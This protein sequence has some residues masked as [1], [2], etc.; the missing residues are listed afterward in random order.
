MNPTIF[1]R[2]LGRANSVYKWLKKS[3]IF[4]FIVETSLLFGAGALIDWLTSDEK[5]NPA[6]FK[7][8][9]PLLHAEVQDDKIGFFVRMLNKL[10]N[11]ADLEYIKIQISIALGLLGGQ[12]TT[13]VEWHDQSAMDDII[14]RIGLKPDAS[15]EEQTSYANNI[16]RNI[17]RTFHFVGGTPTGD[18][19]DMMLYNVGAQVSKDVSWKA[20]LAG[21][22][23]AT[24]QRLTVNASPLTAFLLTGSEYQGDYETIEGVFSQRLRDMTKSAV[25]REFRRKLAQS[26]L[27]DLI[28]WITL[29]DSK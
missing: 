28:F 24:L 21:S 10:A 8:L 7:N 23:D 16:A 29:E 4:V 13:F 11:T 14:N 17:L 12:S 27:D 6:I 25:S 1:L 9:Y 5:D 3:K 18:T 15:N 2:L 26:L 22:L 19:L 20:M